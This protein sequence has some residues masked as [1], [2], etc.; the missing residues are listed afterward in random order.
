MKRRRGALRSGS[1]ARVRAM[2]VVF[3][4]TLLALAIG[5]VS[6]E[7]PEERF[8]RELAQ[9]SEA[10]LTELPSYVDRL[11]AALPDLEAFV[12]DPRGELAVPRPE[13][14]YSGLDFDPAVTEIVAFDFTK[15]RDDGIPWFSVSNLPPGFRPQSQ[16][17]GF[18]FENVAI[19]LQERIFDVGPTA[20]VATRQAVI[21]WLDFI[22]RIPSDDLELIKET[23]QDLDQNP[24]PEALEA[25]I[26]NPREFL[27]SHGVSRETTTEYGIIAVDL[28]KAVEGVMFNRAAAEPGLAVT[29]EA[30]ALFSS[31][32]T[33]DGKYLLAGGVAISEAF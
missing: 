9:L 2:L 23:V 21:V 19:F 25:F 10:T 12:A 20:S 18:V 11:A 22:G 16:A 3:I 31:L 33:D 14:G 27:S 30:I 15:E 8:L 32:E 4:L 17:V 1:R 6:R 7:T 24:S 26:V 29:R 28:T 5:G 13:I